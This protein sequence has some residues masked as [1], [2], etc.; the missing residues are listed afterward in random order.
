MQDV[1]W[2]RGTTTRLTQSA[3][4]ACS[5]DYARVRM[6]G[7]CSGLWKMIFASPM[8]IMYNIFQGRATHRNRIPLRLERP[9]DSFRSLTFISRYPQFV[10]KKTQLSSDSWNIFLNGSWMSNKK[11]VQRYIVVFHSLF[12]QYSL[13]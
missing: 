5:H 10:T 7:T 1:S 2:R 9:I 12:F 8:S 4:N 13:F 11:S 3:N 6:R